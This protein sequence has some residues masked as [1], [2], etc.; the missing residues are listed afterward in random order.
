MKHRIDVGNA[1]PIK[2]PPRR[3]PIHQ[4]EVAEQEINNMLDNGIIESSNSPWASPIVL[5]KKKDGTT[6]FCVDYRK[7]NS[8]TIK[9]AYPLP[10]IDES[11]SSLSGARYFCTLDLASRFWQ[12]AM[13][14]GDKKYTAF[15]THKGLFQFKVMPFG[16]S[17]SP[18][19]FERLM[20]VTLNGLQWER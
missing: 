5:A 8:V 12:V 7:L 11:I 6:R 16:L 4:K 9:D 2:L 13:E 20:E 18:A 14:D 17:N 15:T 10:K 19:T 1:K 3:L